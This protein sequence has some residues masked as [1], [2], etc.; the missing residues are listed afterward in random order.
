MKI[1]QF[2]SALLLGVLSVLVQANEK[3][4]DPATLTPTAAQ[5]QATRLI[6]RFIS[7]YHFKKTPLDDDLSAQIFKRYI[8]SLDPNRS[9]FLASDMEELEAYE[10]FLDDLLRKSRLEPVFEVFRRFRSRVEERSA[11][12]IGLLDTD[13]DFTR[14]EEYRFDRSKASW[15]QDRD[16]LNDIWRKRVKN[17]VLTLRLAGKKDPKEIKE[18]LRKRYERLSRRVAQLNVDDVYQL[19]MNA[20]AGAVEPHTAYLSPRTSENFRI[21]LSLSLEGIGAALRTENEYTV[22]Q[23]IIRGGP[24]D[25][26]GLLHPE[27]RI[28]GVGQG[29]ENIT[30][31]VAWRLEDVVDLIRGPKDSVVRLEVLPKNGSASGPRKVITLVRNK[32]NLDEQAAKKYILETRVGKVGVIELPTFYMDIAAQSRGDKDF[33]S[34][35]RDVGRLIG[36]LQKE[37]VTGLVIDL[38]G[39]GGGALTEAV[40]LSGLFI[41]K[42]PVV[43][44]KDAGG[45]IEVERDPDPGIAYSGPMLVLVD[46][47]SASASEIF[48]GAMQDYGRA[49]VVG[50]PTFGKGTVQSLV[51]LDRFTK[52]DTPHLG[53]LKTT[54]AQFFR[55]SGDS[56]QHRGVVP[57][58]QYPTAFDSKER[59]ERA[60]ENALPWAHVEAAAFDRFSDTTRL[61][62]PVRD[63]YKKRLKNDQ[64]F[65]LLVAEAQAAAEIRDETSASLQESERRTVQK[66][67]EDRRKQL[68]TRFRAAMGLGPKPEKEEPTGETDTQDEDDPSAD[69]WVQE[70]AR[71]LADLVEL[72][73][74]EHLKTA[75]AL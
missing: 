48:A 15:A 7:Q 20:Y 1:T 66:A 13:F 61:V 29:D 22:V 31:V 68:E 36:E 51:N 52:G 74:A 55:V 64:A 33:R 54:I 53:Q 17:D 19:F 75:Q 59:G 43:Q 47:Y 32:I 65:S 9:Y 26:S 56:T 12:A 27:D 37:G 46:R 41:R 71:I 58:I 4:V 73:E 67:R 60:L 63:K 6:T 45:R 40:N 5:Q 8:E 14:E 72:T 30:D 21:H 25:K 50:E 57:D 2:I 16:E 24:A 34:T 18:L 10:Y 28:T 3:I 69:L 11:F 39:N 44:V 42:G 62:R 38:R 70:A 49:V 23:R 35:T